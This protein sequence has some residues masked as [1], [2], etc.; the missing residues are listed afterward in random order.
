MLKNR[1][2]LLILLFIQHSYTITG[3]IPLPEH[4]RPDFER[5]EWINLNGPWDFTFNQPPEE[6][7]SIWHNGFMT[8]DKQILVPFPWGSPLSGVE[9]EGDIGWYKRTV[10]IP[11]SWKGKRVFLVVGASDWQTRGWLDGEYLGE[12][13][14]GYTPFEFDLTS[15]IQW[16]ADQK[17]VLMAD[18]QPAD[19]KLFGKQGYGNARGI[20]QT[21]Y[22]EARGEHF[23]EY[24]HFTP[25]IDNNKVTVSGTLNKPYNSNATIVFNIGDTI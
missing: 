6:G 18:D 20:W 4:P 21:V 2:I 13:S 5:Q 3:Q 1:Q 8:S 24:I 9:D 16:G 14:G 11:E 15:Y 19:F 7:D 25:D 12:N 17:L 23:I 10:K 22:L